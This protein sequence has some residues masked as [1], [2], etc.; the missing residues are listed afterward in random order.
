MSLQYEETAFNL[1]EDCPE[2][3]KSFIM[4]LVLE[5][6]QLKVDKKEQKQVYTKLYDEMT[7]QIKCY[8]RLMEQFTKKCKDVEVRDAVLEE[9]IVATAKNEKEVKKLKLNVRCNKQTIKKL[10][11][12]IKG[13]EDILDGCDYQ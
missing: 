7:E 10:R 8:E 6:Q 5:N 4:S 2:K 1:L 3:V 11:E 13:L 9:Y 12:N